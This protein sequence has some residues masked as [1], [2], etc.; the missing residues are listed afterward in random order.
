MST[1]RINESMVS[2]FIPFDGSQVAILGLNT[3]GCVPTRVYGLIVEATIQE[4]GDTLS[5]SFWLKVATSDTFEIVPGRNVPGIP[6]QSV[7]F[8]AFGEADE[9]GSI[10]GAMVNASL[11]EK[12]DQ[13]SGVKYNSY[14]SDSQRRANPKETTDVEVSDCTLN[15]K[16]TKTGFEI[17]FSDETAV[18]SRLNAKLDQTG[19][20][21]V[22]KL[23]DELREWQHWVDNAYQSA[24]EVRAEN[25]LERIAVAPG[26]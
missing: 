7:D 5:E 18:V 3:N 16:N 17:S 14:F 8:I 9:I 15:A 23:A 11:V 2:S 25:D 13:S 19:I 1:Q 12:Y 21:A 20:E 4:V 6:P 22:L 10:L 26:M 24:K